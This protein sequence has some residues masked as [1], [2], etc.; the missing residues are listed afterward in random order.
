M[1]SNNNGNGNGSIP[2]SDIRFYDNYQPPLDAGDYV[3]SVHQK[4][5]STALAGDGKPLN[6]TFPAQQ[7]FSIKAPRFALDPGDIHSVFPPAGSSGMFDQNLPHVVLT[8][9][10]LPWERYLVAENKTTP[11]LALLLFS[12][13]EIVAPPAPA[14]STLTNPSRAGTYKVSE[15]LQP[16]AGTM[17][18]VINLESQDNADM[19]CRAIDISTS[20]FTKVTPRFDASNSVDDLK[21]LTHCRLV[22]TTDKAILSTKDNGWSSVVIGNRFPAPGAGPVLSVELI[23]EGLN[24]TSAPTVVL[25]GGGGTGAAATAGIDDGVIVSLTLTAGGS[26]YTSPPSITFSGGEGSGATATTQIG[27]PWV[28]HLVSLEGFENYLVDA[29]AWPAS[30]TQVR[31]VSLYSWNFTCLSETGNFRDLMLHLING[32][33]KGGGG[34]LLRLPGPATE[35]APDSLEAKVAQSLNDGY[36][37]VSY[38]TMVGDQTFAWYRSPFIPAPNPDFEGGPYNSAAAAM[39]Y[40]QNSGLF[41]QSYAAAWQTGRL[42]AL[43]DQSF[44]S[45]LLQWRREG[46]RVVNLLSSRLNSSKVQAL[47]GTPDVSQH[48]PETVS[49]LHAL[50]K[51]DLVSA[52]F[53]NHLAGN[54]SDT[55][56]PRLAQTSLADPNQ[57]GNG[58]SNDQVQASQAMLAT[59]AVQQ[60]SSDV[61]TAP[62]TNHVRAFHTMLATPAVQQVLN[63]KQTAAL[64]D[65]APTPLSYITKWLGEL[66]LLYGV[67]FVN[68]VPDAR[69]LPQESLRFFYVDPNYVEALMMGALSIGIQCTRDVHI[70]G[71][72]YSGVS[73]AAHQAKLAVRDQRLGQTPATD[74]PAVSTTIT[75]LLMRSA[76]VAGWPGLEVRAYKDKLATQRINLLR[77]ERVAPD[78][79]LCL[80]A[81]VPACIQISE[82]KESLAFGHEDDFDLDLRWVT[83]EPPGRLIGEIIDGHTV[84]INSYFRSADPGPVLKVAAW[85]G[86]LQTQLNNAYVN[87]NITLG[88]ADFAIQMIRAPE[89]L[90][91]VNS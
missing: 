79:L 19:Q 51:P 91:L 86:Y 29:P 71:V 43:A 88:P 20:T 3:I 38:D 15:I 74:L 26:G 62:T 35:P 5:D 16:P 65:D 2:V 47:V 6:T 8:K 40:D 68:L 56:A 52:S 50:L 59:P 27:A 78:V 28:A 31:L 64:K 72:L 30:V 32:Q 67:P 90:V 44:G 63:D 39:I 4:V 37:A 46:H 22:N 9:R 60:V 25:S 13:D 7:S 12:P 11:W 36:T 80:F 66:C 55:L 58:G 17:G 76:V 77:M 1:G 21:Y 23:E 82:P 48:T 84:K 61:Q 24:Y 87:G 70:Q 69:M 89:E 54:F 83:N 53:M 85:Q 81:D 33:P 73:D 57:A 18:P 41:D 75:G 34:L 45:K 10:N 49:H 42:L 14:T